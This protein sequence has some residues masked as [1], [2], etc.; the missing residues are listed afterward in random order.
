MRTNTVGR[1]AAALVALEGLGLVALLVW[2]V[3]ALVTGDTAS[4]AS[5]LALVVLTAV[6][7]AAVLA[8]AAA[9]WRGRSWGRSGAVVTQLLILAVAL[10]AL[11]GSFAD[12]TIA[13]FLALPA[14]VVLVLVILATRE[15]A[16]HERD[17]APA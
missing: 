8:F 12:P 9:I 15:A 2:Q 5:A 4:I 1:V 17:D 16:R 14:L 7:A 6:G 3:V 10:G 11:T 13:L